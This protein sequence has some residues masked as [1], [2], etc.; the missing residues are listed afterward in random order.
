MRFPRWMLLSPVVCV[1]TLRALAQAPLPELKYEDPPGFYRSAIYPPADF[2]SQEVNASLQVYPFRLFSGDVRLAFS[3]TLMR[4]LVDPRYQESN[5]AA[6]ARLDEAKVAGANLVL[7]AR[8]VEIVAGQRYERMR[9]A[10]VS[11]RAVAIVDASASSMASWQ[12]VLSPLNAFSATLHVVAGAPEPVSSAPSGAAGRAVE[13]LYMGFT[14]KYVADLQRGPAYGSY[15]NAVLYYL[16]S[17]EGRVYRAYDELKVP[18]NDPARFDF[19]DAQRV[20]PANSGQYAIRGESLYVRLGTPQQPET[21]VA[22]LP[23]GNV[24]MI[25]SVRYTRQ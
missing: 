23:S 9:M 20:D 14:R 18:A 5:V 8:F 1:A 4:E 10:V 11:G 2:S 12:R 7:R 19:V 3:R 21:F 24:L 6:G 25:G 13:G 22:R 17:A 16:F 15:V